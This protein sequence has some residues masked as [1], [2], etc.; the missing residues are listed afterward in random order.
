MPR[1]GV[2]I[3][4]RRI[5][6]A[7]WRID[8]K[9]VERRL[10]Q[11]V[12]GQA[13]PAV[14]RMCKEV[15]QGKRYSRSGKPWKHKV[16]FRAR[17]QMRGDDAVLYVFPTGPNKDLWTWTSR[18]TRP[19]PIEAKNA[20]YLVFPY[21]G[22]GARPKTT[23][24][25]GKGAVKFYGGPVRKWASVKKVDHPGTQPRHFEERILKEYGRDFRK[26]I[27]RALTHR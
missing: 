2:A 9:A 1:A 11:A 21:G 4:I 3:G 18:G 14:I 16:S 23:V 19:H 5:D 12:N 15:V 27:R 13:K 17:F 26:I 7:G 8:P 6:T 25:A 10:R 24:P 20:P 22:P